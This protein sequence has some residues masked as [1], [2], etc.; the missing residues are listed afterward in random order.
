RTLHA[1]PTRRSSDLG[2]QRWASLR[3]SKALGIYSRESRSK[4]MDEAS[5]PDPRH[6]SVVHHT[7]GCSSFRDAAASA[8]SSSSALL[9]SLQYRVC[10]Q[11][12]CTAG[13]GGVR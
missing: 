9:V 6:V 5:S 8:C 13:V 12:L 11:D 2:V 3:S 10:D 1:F 7:V 4:L